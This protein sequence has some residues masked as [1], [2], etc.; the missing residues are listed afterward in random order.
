MRFLHV[1]HKKAILWGPHYARDDISNNRS[2]SRNERFH[3]YYTL[4]YAIMSNRVEVFWFLVTWLRS[5]NNN[6]Y[7][8]ANG[9]APS[10]VHNNNNVTND[11]GVRPALHSLTKLCEF[12]CIRQI[13]W[14][15]IDLR[16]DWFEYEGTY[17]PA[18]Y[19]FQKAKQTRPFCNGFSFVEWA[20]K[21]GRVIF[22]F[23]PQK[24]YFAGAPLYFG[25]TLFDFHFSLCHFELVEKS[26]TKCPF[27]LTQ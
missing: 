23:S 11:N 2:K 21:S 24:S 12:S 14:T 7:N 13:L 22:L 4:L 18:F 9:L 5:G 8:N 17:Y 3:L 16:T 25:R 6:N 1:P 26:P 20:W 19:N 15:N 10:G 27:S